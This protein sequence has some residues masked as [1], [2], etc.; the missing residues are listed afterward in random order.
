MADMN[1]SL[2]NRVRLLDDANDRALLQALNVLQLAKVVQGDAVELQAKARSV[3]GV[4]AV[5]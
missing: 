3:A 2:S 1:A 5:N 4:L